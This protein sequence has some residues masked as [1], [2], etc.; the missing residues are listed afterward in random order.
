MKIFILTSV[1]LF[2]EYG[3]LDSMDDPSVN[4]SVFLTL[5]GAKGKMQAELETEKEDAEIAGYDCTTESHERTASFESGEKGSGCSWNLVT[6][7]I[8]EKEI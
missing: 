8:V 3:D 4:T 7:E 1:A 2:A 5:E 6:W